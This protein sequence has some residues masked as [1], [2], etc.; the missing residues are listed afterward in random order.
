[1]M[2]KHDTAFRLSFFRPP[3]RD[4]ERH[5][6]RGVPDHAANPI[7]PAPLHPN[8]PNQP[9]NQIYQPT[10]TCCTLRFFTVRADVPDAQVQPQLLHHLLHRRRRRPLRRAHG[11]SKRHQPLLGQRRRGGRVD[12]RRGRVVGGCLRI[13]W[14]TCSRR[15]RWRDGW[16]GKRRDRERVCV[17]WGRR[18][19]AQ[20][21]SQKSKRIVSVCVLL[22]HVT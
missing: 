15:R 21:R 11:P 9:T 22:V 5:R 17:G 1:M 18:R 14:C 10:R 4:R 16:K 2:T 8:R 7:L 20:K 6:D 12:M 3:P 13:V 19:A